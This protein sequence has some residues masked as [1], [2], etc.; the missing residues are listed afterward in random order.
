MVVAL[1]SGF[2]SGVGPR[3]W[4][5]QAGV[6]LFFVVSGFIMVYVSRDVFGKP[7]AAIDFLQRRIIRIVPLYWI[8]TGAFVLLI[9]HA[10]DK[11]VLLSMFFVPFDPFPIVRPGWTLNYEMAFYLLFAGFLWLSRA[12]AVIALCALLVAVVLVGLV[13]W[14]QSFAVTFYCNPII[15][16][17]GFGSLIGLAYCEGIRLSKGIALLVAA[18]G[19]TGFTAVTMYYG[20]P[21]SDI[22]RLRFVAWGLPAVC[23]VAAAALHPWPRRA[24][25]RP[26]VLLG[27]A[28]FSL[29]LSHWITLELAKRLGVMQGAVV[30]LLAVAGGLAVWLAV[31]RPITARRKSFRGRT[32]LKNKQWR[33]QSLPDSRYSSGA[34]DQ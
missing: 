7:G 17:F 34:R 4:W 22:I 20:D 2:H 25:P 26:L 30:F 10:V 5:G 29:Y 32:R 27:E 12:K 14:Q 8:A 13:A 1:H 21:Y 24:T 33:I 18:A 3:F 28:S 16:E 19:I 15:L 31:E 23:L 11:Y 6:D 9:N